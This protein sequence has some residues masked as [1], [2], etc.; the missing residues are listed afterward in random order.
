MN[1]IDEAYTFLS[2]LVNFEKTTVPTA[3]QLSLEPVKSLL[4]S[5]GDPHHDLKIIH[6]AGTKG[7]GSVASM[8]ESILSKA[9]YSTGL[10]TSPHIVD[11]TDRFRVNCR[12]I[13]IEVL[14][15]I[16]LQIRAQAYQSGKVCNPTPSHFDVST[17]LAFLYFKLMRVDV[18]IIEV[19]MGGRV[20]STN[21][22]TPMVSVITNIG[23]D[24]VKQLGNTLA[25]I[26]SEKAGIIKYGR[27]TVTGIKSDEALRI[28]KQRCHEHESRLSILGSDFS[29]KY[30]TVTNAH[31]SIPSTSV[32]V[33][34]KK[35]V[36]PSVRLAMIGEHQAC[37][38]SVA[39]A[40]VEVLQDLGYSISTVDVVDALSCVQCPA[41]VEIV[42][43]NPHIILDCAHNT[44]SAIA[45]AQSLRTIQGTSGGPAKWTLIY[46]SS[47]DKDIAGVLRQLTPLFG[48]IILTT[49]SDS[50]RSASEDELRA[51]IAANSCRLPVRF[52][53][54]PH[55]ALRIALEESSSNHALCI[56]GTVFMASELWNRLNAIRK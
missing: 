18:A 37:N 51:A 16:V 9:G 7:K 31:S 1:V 13:R 4:A 54:D 19:G 12:P 21:V 45:L 34:T 33:S 47:R 38:A 10:Y 35:Q 50:K 20:D 22:C 3:R 36:W 26:A 27:P 46:A 24:H 15:E 43:T 41:R 42:S 25:A 29:Y 52:I 49:Y 6:I 30:Q 44:S 28:V 32:M 56:T 17:A 11:F 14:S 40:T 5:L 48:S 39:I 8:L 2:E 53:Q 23:F 55:E